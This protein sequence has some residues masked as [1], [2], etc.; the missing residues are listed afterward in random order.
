MGGFS[1]TAMH[2][3][4]PCQVG[5]SGWSQSRRVQKGVGLSQQRHGNFRTLSSPA[6]PMIRKL[7]HHWRNSRMSWPNKP[8][9]AQDKQEAT[10]P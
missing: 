8:A 9:Q 10:F 5:S 3:I 1:A 4:L 2:V 7:P 6:Q